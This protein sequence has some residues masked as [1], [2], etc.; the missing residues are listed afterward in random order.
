MLSISV[1]IAYGPAIVDPNRS[2]CEGRSADL[3]DGSQDARFV[4]S[5]V[6][7]IEVLFIV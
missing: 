6:P 4:T 5:C 7:G 2:L 1:I 3:G